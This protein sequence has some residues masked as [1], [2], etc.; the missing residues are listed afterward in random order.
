[1]DSNYY[2]PLWALAWDEDSGD[3][4]GVGGDYSILS[5]SPAI[6][7]GFGYYGQS[8]NS[9]FDITTYNYFSVLTIGFFLLVFL[10]SN[11]IN[12]KKVDSETLGD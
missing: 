4:G 6:N 12:N 7:Y 8:G 10:T 5:W 9:F 1:M 3:F 2:Y 11:Y